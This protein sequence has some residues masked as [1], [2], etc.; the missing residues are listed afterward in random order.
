LIFI[1]ILLSVETNDDVD[2][3]HLH[4]HGGRGQFGHDHLV[5]GDILDAA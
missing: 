5:R 2:P 3:A 1:S 4:A